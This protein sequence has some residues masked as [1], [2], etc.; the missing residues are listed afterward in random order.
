MMAQLICYHHIPYLEAMA[1]SAGAPGVD[2]QVHIKQ[3]LEQGHRHSGINLANPGLD[4][5]H[6]LARELTLVEGVASY[7]LL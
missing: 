2:D 7:N 5:D 6:V 3:L 4:Q 1:Q